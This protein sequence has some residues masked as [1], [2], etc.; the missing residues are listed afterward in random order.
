MNAPA[1]AVPVPARAP[2]RR[3]RS[4]AGRLAERNARLNLP[5]PQWRANPYDF[6]VGVGACYDPNPLVPDTG[7]PK[8]HGEVLRQNRRWRNVQK[9]KER[10]QHPITVWDQPEPPET[11]PKTLLHPMW[12]AASTTGPG[13]LEMITI[14]IP[15]K[16][17]RFQKGT[18]AHWGGASRFRYNKTL[19]F[20]HRSAGTTCK[21][22]MELMELFKCDCECVSVA[23]CACVRH[24]YVRW[25]L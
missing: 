3:E 11:M 9:G 4:I 20:L 1:G 24:T 2:S 12:S 15:L 5:D 19:H 18:L 6:S 21:Q 23:V 10:G 22:G 25:R 8:T 14:K 13:P 16:P 7:K 17:S